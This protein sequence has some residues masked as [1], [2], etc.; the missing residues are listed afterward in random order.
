MK[1]GKAVP[2][3]DRNKLQNLDE[4]TALEIDED[5][6]NV[7]VSVC[8][9][10]GSKAKATPAETARLDTLKTALKT[11]V[12]LGAVHNHA[13]SYTGVLYPD[14]IRLLLG[15][16][17]DFASGKLVAADVDAGLWDRCYLI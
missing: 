3:E 8:R 7:Y 9:P 12:D 16:P 14:C 17:S 2:I 11:E 15:D 4:F 13:E 5:G 6:G 10:D 1:D